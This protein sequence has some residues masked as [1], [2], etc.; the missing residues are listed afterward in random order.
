MLQRLLLSVLACTG[1]SGCLTPTPQGDLIVDLGATQS[2][3]EA[4]A[5]GFEDAARVETDRALQ[6]ALQG[7]AVRLGQAAYILDPEIPGSLEESLGLARLTLDGLSRYLRD[8]RPEALEDYKAIIQ[9]A[10]ITIS[11][12]QTQRSP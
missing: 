7:V 12:M 1:L 9:S 10:Y 2:T 6:G 4:L 5:A 3:L 11:V 8:E